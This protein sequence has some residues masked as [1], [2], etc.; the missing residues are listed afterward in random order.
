M[1]LL[2]VADR[3]QL[4][5]AQ[6]VVI[7]DHYLHAPVDPRCRPLCY[8]LHY[9]YAFGAHAAAGPRCVGILM[10]GRP[11]ATRCYTGGLTYGSQADVDA[12]RAT[13]D[14]WEVLNLARVWFAPVVQPGGALHRLGPASGLPGFIDRR[15]LW[16]STL[17]S[18]TIG[19]ALARVGY[20]YLAARP[21][22]DCADPYQIRA[23]PSY[24]DTRVHRGTIYRASGFQLAR[25]NDDGIETW[26]TTDVAPL[27]AASDAAIRQ[28]AETNPRSQRIRARRQQLSLFQ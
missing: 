16:R 2:S 5:W 7:A 18:H 12:G 6:E 20:D 23:V 10:F 15:G 25:T 28:L 9:H 11:E 1:L 8:L 21:P 22:V 13:F 19:L 26:Y 27:S 3:D 4:A 14:R 17:A 24:C